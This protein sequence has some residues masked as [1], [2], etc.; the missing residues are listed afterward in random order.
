MFVYA[1]VAVCFGGLVLYALSSNPKP[2]EV[3]RLMFKEGLLVSLLLFGA[4][5]LKLL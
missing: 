2:A 1:S 3:G 5:A 4:K